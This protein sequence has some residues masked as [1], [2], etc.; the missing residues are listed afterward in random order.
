MAK[1]ARARRRTAGHRRTLPP[2]VP[3]GV[4]ALV[5]ALVVV[6]PATASTPNATPAARAAA[7]AVTTLL[8]GPRWDEAT[9]VAL[10]AAGNRLISGSTMSG[11]F[12]GSR[13]EGP[14]G[15]VDAFV[16]KLSATGT[17]L[18]SVVFGG[19]GV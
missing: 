13:A 18:W 4:A 5:L 2:L 3:V 9:G 6:R 11:A 10:D 1:H 16:A 8:G 12:P 14:G 15:L 19:S 7:P 17:L